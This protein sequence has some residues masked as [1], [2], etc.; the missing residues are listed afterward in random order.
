MPALEPLRG[1]RVVAEPAALDA[2]RWTAAAGETVLTLR[3]APDD[4]LA[5]GAAAVEVDD[6]HAIVEDE[7]GY[8]GG[9]GSARELARH[10]E[11][12]LPSARPALAQGSIAGVPAKVWL[13]AGDDPDRALLVATAAA[14]PVLAERIGWSRR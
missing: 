3:L 6:P 8:V 5:I 14:S 12:S 1:L 10:A 4:V 2:A 13:P 11:W 9:W 7:R